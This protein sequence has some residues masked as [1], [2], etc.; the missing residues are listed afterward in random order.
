M[1]YSTA[2][3]WF[4]ILALGLGTYLIRFS[5]LGSFWRAADAAMAASAPEI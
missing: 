4:I 5:F 1:T 2:S 3:L